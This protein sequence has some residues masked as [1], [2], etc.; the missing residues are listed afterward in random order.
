MKNFNTLPWMTVTMR[1]DRHF[2]IGTT[3]MGYGD[4]SFKFGNIY[5][6]KIQLYILQARVM[7]EDTEKFDRVI[8]F[9]KQFTTDLLYQS[10]PSFL[11][12]WSVIER[13]ILIEKK[14]H[15]I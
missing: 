2:G 7:I 6:A 14:G 8:K 11:E 5:H 1:D 10:L 4:R 9:Y 12:S 3:I 15:Y 13:R